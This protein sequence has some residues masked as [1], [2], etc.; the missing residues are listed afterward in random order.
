LK[1]LDFLPAFLLVQAALLFSKLGFLPVW[2]DENDTLRRAADPHLLEYLCSREV[3]PPLYFL[4]MKVWL[5]LPW[6]GDPI[7][8]ARAWSGL[9]ALA[10]TVVVYRLWLR[11]LE[12]RRRVWFLSLWTLSP[13]LVM[14]GRM[15]RSYTFQMLLGAIA[16]WAALRLFRSPSVRNAIVYGIAACLMLYAHYATGLA[17]SGA[18]LVW[19]L[20]GRLYRPALISSAAITVA[21]VPWLPCLLRALG[22]VEGHEPYRVGNFAVDQM[23]RLGYWFVSFSLGETPPVWVLAAGIVIGPLILWAIWNA[24]RAAFAG[25]GSLAAPRDSVETNYGSSRQ[26]LLWIVVLTAAGI[27]Y[28]GVSRWVSFAFVPA[29]VLF[30]L[31]FFFL[32]LV[33]GQDS[34]RLRLVLVIGLSLLSVASLASYFRGEDF[35]NKGYLIPF[36]RIAGSIGAPQGQ[37][38]ILESDGFDV[39]P[40]R[41]LLKPGIEAQQTPS[42]T[43][44]R[45]IREVREQNPRVPVWY[46]RRSTGP[47]PPGAAR[48]IGFV[49]YSNLDKTILKVLD[50][51]TPD[52]VVELIEYPAVIK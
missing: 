47:P 24:V 39:S 45:V 7:L 42:Q 11:D 6:P 18:V 26:G 20:V 50:R 52:F 9:C 13:C 12:P 48:R 25:T 4:L 5:G 14:Y 51:T 28:L 30:L 37:I 16:L 36:E 23:V 49:P 19:L 41:D 27:G 38:V 33:S 10:A 29:R 21:Y 32:A 8:A 15:G 3:H 46:L 43:A 2:G 31:P 35:L 34:T 1:R 44:A 40:L 17:V 22:R